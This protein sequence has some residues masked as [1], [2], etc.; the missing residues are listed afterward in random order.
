MLFVPML[1]VLLL[2]I[3]MW[4]LTRRHGGCLSVILLMI[5]G[6][7]L[8]LWADIPTINGGKSKDQIADKQW[9][10]E[11]SGLSTLRDE[12]P[13]AKAPRYL[14]F[15][16]IVAVLPTTG[17]HLRYLWELPLQS[18]EDQMSKIIA[19]AGFTRNLMRQ[20]LQH[21]T[22]DR[23][24]LYEYLLRHPELQEHLL[25]HPDPGLLLNNSEPTLLNVTKEV[26][27]E[28]EIEVDDE[29]W[30]AVLEWLERL[31]EALG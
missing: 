18:T 9:T 26:S 28:V 31:S 4:F 14:R 29:K 12:N 19:Y 16:P 24:E 17:N 23:T 10:V 13:F 5:M 2:G 6:S 21:F 25:R 20:H 1:V 7:A 30:E 11:P 22:G 8:L 27:P 3:I 15:A